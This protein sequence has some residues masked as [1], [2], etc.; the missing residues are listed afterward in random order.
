MGPRRWSRGYPHPR[1]ACTASSARFNGAAAMEPRIR[2]RMAGVAVRVSLQWGR[3]DGAADTPSATAY[4]EMLV[5]LQWGRG[6]G[7]AD[8]ACAGMPL[9]ARY[10]S[11]PCEHGLCP[12]FPREAF[13]RRPPRVV[14][15]LQVVRPFR[16]LPAPP[17]T[18]TALAAASSASVVDCQGSA[19]WALVVCLPG[20]CRVPET[21]TTV[22][23]PRAAHPNHSGGVQRNPIIS[24]I[25]SHPDLRCRHA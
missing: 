25:P 16:A 2:G 12:G 4:L 1:T 11:M 3:G 18:T 5:R 14:L 22:S 7:A 21:R 24:D 10:Q 19:A 17:I 15:H 23:R 20:S 13:D 9:N 6:D 8:T